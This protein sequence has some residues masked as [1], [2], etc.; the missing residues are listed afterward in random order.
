M[1]PHLHISKCRKKQVVCDISRSALDRLIDYGQPRSI[2][3][4]KA[5]SP[6]SK[7]FGSSAPVIVTNL[8]P[9]VDASSS[10]TKVPIDAI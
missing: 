4:H 1:P 7:F 2:T 5:I 8:L 9:A 3:I 6:A 10:Q